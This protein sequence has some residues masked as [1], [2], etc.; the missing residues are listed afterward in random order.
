VPRRLSITARQ[1]AFID[2]YTSGE[3]LGNATQ[4]AIAAGTPPDSAAQ[5]GYKWLRIPHV[6][7]AVAERQKLR[8]EASVLELKQMQKLL[9]DF[10]LDPALAVR[11]RLAAMQLLG[12]T[13]GDFISKIGLGL[14]ES[15]RDLV[16][17]SM[18][19]DEP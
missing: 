7:A 2:A 19:A 15:L 5:Q 1:Q 10:A 6:A 3:T 13:R 11:D 12:K 14:D 17:E 16:R 8:T 4:A 18:G 9:S